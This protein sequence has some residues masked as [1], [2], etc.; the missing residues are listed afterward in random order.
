MN[1]NQMAIQMTNLL[2]NASK[3]TSFTTLVDRIDDPINSGI[4]AYLEDKCLR[5]IINEEKLYSQ[6]Y[7]WDRL[8]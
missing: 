2:A 5:R 4:A 3:T 6:L 8:R 7:D 1:L